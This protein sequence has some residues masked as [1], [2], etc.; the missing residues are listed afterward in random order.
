MLFRSKH[1]QHLGNF[2]N[3]NDAA[4]AYNAK[5]KELFGEFAFL[6]DVGLAE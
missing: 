6:N 5:A 3:E 1:L 2:E 4:L